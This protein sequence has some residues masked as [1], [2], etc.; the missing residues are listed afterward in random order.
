MHI[1]E[2]AHGYMA[3][4]QRAAARQAPAAPENV[5]Q[6]AA[7]ARSARRREQARNPVKEAI[8][9]DL[10]S[11][12]QG[13]AEHLQRSRQRR[14][15]KPHKSIMQ[16][17]VRVKVLVVA[18]VCILAYLTFN[19]AADAI[20]LKGSIRT[21]ATYAFIGG[22]LLYLFVTGDHVEEMDDYLRRH[23]GHLGYDHVAG[24]HGYEDAGVYAPHL[25]RE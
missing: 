14:R 13:T 16:R 8:A 11:D 20:N 9:A 6:G 17:I 21:I 18:I 4:R 1:A 2:N 25:L 22:G 7:P 12:V 10:I 15:R 5:Q 19:M 23:G 24:Y 3:D